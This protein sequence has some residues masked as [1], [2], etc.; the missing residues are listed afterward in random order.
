[1]TSLQCLITWFAHIIYFLRMLAPIGASIPHK[2]FST[3]L[4]LKNTIQMISFRVGT[5]CSFSIV[6][7]GF[8]VHSLERDR[9]KMRNA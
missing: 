8:M 7:Y 9:E 1:V 4:V 3:A 5:I 6:L 2:F